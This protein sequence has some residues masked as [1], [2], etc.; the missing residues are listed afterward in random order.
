M[1]EGLLQTDQTIDIY[2]RTCKRDDE[3]AEL[4][5]KT[6]RDNGFNGK[7]TFV[8]DMEYNTELSKFSDVIVSE[9]L[10]K[11]NNYGGIAGAKMIRNIIKICDV[12][13]INIICDSDIIV[14][15]DFWNYLPDADHIGCGEVVKGVK[16]VSGQMQILGQKLTKTVG[17]YSDKDIESIVFDKMIPDGH[18][19]ADDSF[20]SYVSHINQYSVAHI[21]N[22]TMWLHEKRYSKK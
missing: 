11:G 1:D 15:S 12:S 5:Y 2:I 21:D 16:M 22:S 14:L 10:D 18:N 6:F 17:S 13:K 9:T 19:I 4:C 20:L 3:L 7:I 8:C